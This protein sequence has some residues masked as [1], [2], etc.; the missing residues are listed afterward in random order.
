MSIETLL[1]ALDRYSEIKKRIET[2][3]ASVCSE[4]DCGIAS[5][6]DGQ[7]IS[8]DHEQELD[9]A[10]SAFETALNRHIDERIGSMLEKRR[11][12]Q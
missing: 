3:K 9:R 12:C 4:W 5:E 2:E 11:G 10:R 1:A 7:F 8:P 6:L